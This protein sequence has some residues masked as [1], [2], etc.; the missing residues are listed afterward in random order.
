MS[1]EDILKNPPPLD[2][3]DEKEINELMRFRNMDRQ[4]AERTIRRKKG[5]LGQR[6]QVSYADYMRSR[7]EEV[8]KF[9]RRF[10]KVVTN[11]K[12]GRKKTVKFGQAGKAKDGGDRI[13]PNTSKGDAYCARSNK[14]KGDW[15]K[16]PNSPNN[17]SRKKWKCH[18]NKSSK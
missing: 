7:K 2:A 8:L 10:K 9:K 1:W 16:D 18:G 6:K 14:I 4:T 15:R 17:L 13:R 3:N 5:K 12:T 11:K